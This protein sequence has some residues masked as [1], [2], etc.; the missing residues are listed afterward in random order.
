LV[1]FALDEAAATGGSLEFNGN[2]LVLGAPVPEFAYS[3][4][5]E[6]GSGWGITEVGHYAFY[7]VEERVLCEPAQFCQRLG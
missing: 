2:T 1:N 4:H 5:A 6:N 7:P 3:I